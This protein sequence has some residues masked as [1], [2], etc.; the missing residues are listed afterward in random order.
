[1]SEFLKVFNDGDLVWAKNA[2]AGSPELT[3]D[4]GVRAIETSS[5]AERGLWRFDFPSEVAQGDE[6]LLRA[7]L[8]TAVE[9]GTASIVAVYYAGDDV[10]R[11]DTVAEYTGRIASG[12]VEYYVTVPEG[13]TA[14]RLDFRLWNAIGRFEIEGV[15]VALVNPA[16]EPP[17]GEPSAGDE[18]SE[19]SA[20]DEVAARPVL[21]RVTFSAPIVEGET[22]VLEVVD[23][24]DPSR[25][26]VW[27][28]RM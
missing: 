10:L 28:C 9:E 7:V 17:A 25:R 5:T 14:V 16:Y 15:Q 26:R 6:I 2:H 20:G 13:A 19:P 18:G 21:E 23:T 12:G 11:V 27:L 4:G 1:M 22:L 8:S 3:H 24:A